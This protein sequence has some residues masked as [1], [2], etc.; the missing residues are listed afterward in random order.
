MP[1]I[2]LDPNIRRPVPGAGFC[3]RRFRRSRAGRRSGAG[4]VPPRTTLIRSTSSTGA[5]QCSFLFSRA[6]R[7]VRGVAVLLRRAFPRTSAARYAR[8]VARACRHG[9]AFCFGVQAR[10]L[11]QR[12]RCRRRGRNVAR[13]PDDGDQVRSSRAG[14]NR[15][16]CGGRPVHYASRRCRT[17]DRSRGYGLVALRH[18]RRIPA[19][20]QPGDRCQRS[21]GTGKVLPDAC[22]CGSYCGAPPIRAR[23]CA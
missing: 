6:R 22:S 8:S 2:M 10:R 16:G 20:R 21:C 12:C 9:G 13:Q 4:V 14:P 1:G 7:S 11:R 15:D 17:R 19:T 18:A 3:R 5:P 23:R